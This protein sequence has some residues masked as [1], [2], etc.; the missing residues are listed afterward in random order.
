MEMRRFSSELTTLF[1][2][3]RAEPLAVVDPG[4]RFVIATAD[5]LCGM[6][7][8]EAPGVFDLERVLDRLGGACP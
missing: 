1:F 8:A 5:S 6:A 7:K 4:E 2:D 3:P